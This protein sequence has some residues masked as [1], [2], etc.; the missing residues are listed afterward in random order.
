MFSL[1][2]NNL[3]FNTSYFKF[4]QCKQISCHLLRSQMIFWSYKLVNIS[5]V[6]LQKGIF[7]QLNVIS[8]HKLERYWAWDERTMP[9]R[10]DKTTAS[11]SISRKIISNIFPSRV[12]IISFNLSS[13][14]YSLWIFFLFLWLLL[15]AGFSYVFVLHCFS[16]IF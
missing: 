1:S 16:N 14:Y 2:L 10:Y 7:Q 12:T 6:E 15:L 11:A 8:R 13:L 4:L 5:T 9:A 3:L